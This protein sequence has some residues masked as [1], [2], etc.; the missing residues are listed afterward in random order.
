MIRA[1]PI[2]GAL[3]LWVALLVALPCARAVAQGPPADYRRLVGDAV[4][5][6]EE[7][8]WPEARALFE[9]AH[10]LYPN[11][12]TLRGIGMCAFEM[13]DYQDA[14]ENLLFAL[15]DTRRPL[16]PEQRRATE[17]LAER[18]MGFIGR[19]ALTLEPPEAQL[20]VD[21]AV[22]SPN[23]RG[24]LILA[25]GEHELVVRA[26]GFE[27]LHRRIDVHGGESEDLA[28]VLESISEGPGE[29]PIASIALWIAGGTLLLAVPAATGWLI[30]RD[31][32]LTDCHSPPLGYRCGNEAVLVEQRDAAIGTLIGLG[33]AALGAATAGLLVWILA[34]GAEGSATLECR[35]HPG[36]V[37][38]SF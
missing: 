31:A 16:T 4:G 33:A 25:V 27:T 36:G 24:E 28:L 23:R 7:A 26:A 14:V 6:F 17:D 34:G 2:A 15:E 10:D 22:V 13:R 20:T 9:R 30:N 12:R 32:A 5:E 35:P 19:F 1:V 29:P 11:A 3:P 21:D 18:A 38:C 37:R 8:N